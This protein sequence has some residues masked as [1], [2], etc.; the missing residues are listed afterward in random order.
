MRTRWKSAPT[1]G[2]ASSVWPMR[3]L[4]WRYTMPPFVKVTDAKKP[5]LMNRWGSRPR[6]RRPRISARIESPMSCATMCA[7]EMLSASH[8]SSDCSAWSMTLYEKSDA[9]VEPGRACASALRGL[10]LNPKPTWS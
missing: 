9:A 2:V 4:I 7:R 8:S 1:C 3:L 5:R 6:W 10:S